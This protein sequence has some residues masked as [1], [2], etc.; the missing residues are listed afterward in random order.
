[1]G[2]TENRGYILKFMADG[3]AS[4]VSRVFGP[5]EGDV[6]LN[7]TLRR[8]VIA[9]VTAY[10]PNGQPATDADVGLVSPGARRG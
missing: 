1:M 9:T 5:D 10:N 3:Y 8:A 2:G 6:E 4:F 7:V